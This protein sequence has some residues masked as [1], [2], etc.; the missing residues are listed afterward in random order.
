MVSATGSSRCKQ[1]ARCG[2][3]T[4]TGSQRRLLNEGSTLH[5]ATAEDVAA[6]REPAV[7]GGGDESEDEED[8]RELVARSPANGQ[9]G[10]RELRRN[11]SGG[12]R[13]GDGR[14]AARCG[15][16][17][18]RVGPPPGRGRARGGD[19]RQGAALSTVQV[20]AQRCLG[21]MRPIPRR[22]AGLDLTREVGVAAGWPVG[23]ADRSARHAPHGGPP[24][25][26]VS[27][28]SRRPKTRNTRPPRAEGR[29]R[30]RRPPFRRSAWECGMPAARGPRAILIGERATP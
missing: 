26:A 29:A 3:R 16:S 2:R 28:T 6:R 5:L 15:H 12:C 7:D 21:G 25:C 22:G 23:V 20:N 1:A 11:V 30:G 8:D 9:G 10:R 18:A 27:K 13:Q 4:S 17:A 19:L 14:R 24:R